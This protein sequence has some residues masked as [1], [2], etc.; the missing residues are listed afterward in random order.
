M[1]TR[2]ATGFKSLRILLKYYRYPK[3]Q[4][5][6]V[7]NILYYSVVFIRQI[8]VLGLRHW[9]FTGKFTNFLKQQKQ[10]RCSVKN[11]FIKISQYSHENTCVGVTLQ[12]FRIA[13]L[14]ETPTQMFSCE[15]C[16]I[17]KDTYFK[18]HLRTTAS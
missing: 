1:Q 9:Y 15:Y 11:V 2:K 17:F 6:L 10:W 12:A 18:E 8:N 3:F 4:P 7:V 14:L 5:V 13:T 16:K